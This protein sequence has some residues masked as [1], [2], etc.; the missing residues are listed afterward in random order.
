MP[1]CLMNGIV[2][3]A[4]RRSLMLLFVVTAGRAV[5]SEQWSILSGGG[6]QSVHRVA[7]G[8]PIR[9]ICV[10]S[11]QCS[12]IQLQK[13]PAHCLRLEPSLISVSA[14]LSLPSPICEPRVLRFSKKETY[15]IILSRFPK[16]FLIRVRI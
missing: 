4:R 8:E 6:R 16:A 1:L 14:S 15:I 13:G 2:V 5:G 9:R 3:S 7:R 12:W 10:H 11:H